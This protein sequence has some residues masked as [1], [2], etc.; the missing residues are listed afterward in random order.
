MLVRWLA[1]APHTT[2]VLSSNPGWTF[3]ACR[4]FSVNSGI[5]L[6]FMACMALGSFVIL[7]WTLAWTATCLRDVPG[8]SIYDSCDRLISA[9]TLD[10]LTWDPK[11]TYLVLES[12]SSGQRRNCS[13]GIWAL[14]TKGGARWV[15]TNYSK[16]LY[17]WYQRWYWYWIDSSEIWSIFCFY[18]WSSDV[19]TELC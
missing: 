6:E 15:Q 11:T 17:Y 13:F 18:P 4:F 7:N 5:L 9:V 3:F 2:K 8:F 14:A 19:A 1:L 16:Y 12:A 10:I